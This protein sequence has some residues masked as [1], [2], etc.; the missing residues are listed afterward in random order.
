M[1]RRAISSVCRQTFRDFE[2]IVV[3]DGSTTSCL[4]ALSDLRDARIRSITNSCNIGVAGARNVGIEDARGRYISFLDDDDEYRSSFLSSTYACLENT[5]ASVGVSWCSVEY[6][7]YAEEPTRKR[8]A[9]VRDFAT[10]YA[11]SCTLFRQF[12]S[13]GMSFGVTIKASCLRQVG[14]FNTALKVE[15][16]TDLFYR[17]LSHGFAPITVPGV[18]IL[19]HDH[20]MV[21][22]TG[23]AMLTES[24]RACKGFFR[25]YSELMDKY[26][27]LRTDLLLY[28]ASLKTRLQSHALIADD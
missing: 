19:R 16:D 9:E 1:L 7:R 23:P 15:E 17:V 4:S 8:P 25:Q 12:L 22:L 24:I 26:P 20:H 13:I 14:G 2:L 3:D 5:P 18:H 11:N 21:R 6:I 28:L 10:E 27:L